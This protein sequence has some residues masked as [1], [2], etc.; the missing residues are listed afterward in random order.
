MIGTANKCSVPATDQLTEVSRELDAVGGGEG[1]L[2]ALPPGEAGRGEVVDAVVVVEGVAAPR[3]R[4][5]DG[6]TFEAVQPLHAG[7]VTGGGGGEGGG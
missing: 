6:A 2:S 7:W 3:I 4:P 5:V 1:A